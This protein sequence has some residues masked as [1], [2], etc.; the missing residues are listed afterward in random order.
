MKIFGKVQTGAVSQLSVKEQKSVFS[1]DLIL[2]RENGHIR[3]TVNSIKCHQGL[4]EVL[5]C[6]HQWYLEVLPL[7]KLLVIQAPCLMTVNLGVSGGAGRWSMAA[8][9]GEG[10]EGKI[11]LHVIN[12][13]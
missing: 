12:L 11:Y 9:Q 7:H 2:V 1:N 3:T 10:A 5:G 4:W 13:C 6:L 8:E